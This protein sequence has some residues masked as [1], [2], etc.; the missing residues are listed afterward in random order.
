[1]RETFE[2]E[3]TRHEQVHLV[4]T[5]DDLLIF[6]VMEVEDAEASLEAFRSSTLPIDE[7]HKEVMRAAVAESVAAEVLLTS[8]WSGPTAAPQYPATTPSSSCC[9]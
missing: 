7:Q 5:S 1:V 9:R 4:E 2:R 8:L 3:G 6:Y